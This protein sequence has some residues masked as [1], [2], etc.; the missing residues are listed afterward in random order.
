MI[1]ASLIRHKENL[2]DAEILVLTNP[3]TTAILIL[4]MDSHRFF[5]LD[6]PTVN[7]QNPVLFMSPVG[8]FFFRAW[9]LT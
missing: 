1:Q 7:R 5:N 4:L 3:Q 6:A 9:R 2:G 8:A